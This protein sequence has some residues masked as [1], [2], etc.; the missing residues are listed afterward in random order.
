[1]RL[2]LAIEGGFRRS[3]A[4]FAVAVEREVAR[5]LAQ[6]SG[7]EVLILPASDTAGELGAARLVAVE[8]DDGGQARARFNVGRPIGA[9][10]PGGLIGRG[11]FPL[12]LLPEADALAIIAAGSGGVFA[13]GATPG[14]EIGE[15]AVGF[16]VPAELEATTGAVLAT[17][18]RETS[19]SCA[20]TGAPLAADALPVA[21][22]WAGPERLHLNNLLLLSPA[23]ETAFREGHLTIRDDFSLIV[24][25]RRID[26]E[27]AER[28][29]P[30]GRL[31]VPDN[32]L[33]Q[34]SA[35][36]LAWHRRWVFGLG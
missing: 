33:L 12:Q 7:A 21:I 26:P 23:A 17:L 2:A 31:R 3:E 34:P 20:L 19:N 29:N 30:D 22:R 9:A 27:L 18:R 36:N 8:T 11:P 6:F 13:Q 1:M 15:R 16:D 28:L 25:L 5:M 24:D 32:P 4:G 10:R 14:G 35:M